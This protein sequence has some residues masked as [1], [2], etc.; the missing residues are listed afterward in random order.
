M[1]SLRWLT[2]TLTR[3]NDM[4]DITKGIAV[5]AAHSQKNKVTE[6]QGIDLKTGEIIF[7]QNLGNQTINIGEFLAIVEAAK[8]I[9]KNDYEPKVIFSDSNV[10]ISWFKNKQ[11]ASAKKNLKL[12]KAEIYLKI[13]A[14]WVDEIK[15]VHWDNK[16]W[17]ET[18]ADFGNK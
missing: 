14:I 17:G 15:V 18:P 4:V 3:L 16:A 6:F 8:W 13:A 2:L 11:T 1:I 7:Y 12:Q 5:D 10:A 9:I